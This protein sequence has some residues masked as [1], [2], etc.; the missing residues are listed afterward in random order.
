MINTNQIA[1][2]TLISL[3]IVGCVL[4]LY[5]FMPAMLFAVKLVLN[6]KRP[7]IAG[8]GYEKI[9]I[10]LFPPDFGIAEVGLRD[11]KRGWLVLRVLTAQRLSKKGP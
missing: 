11:V 8:G 4:V 1:R 9:N 5:P 6:D 3:L 2:M 7:A 10:L